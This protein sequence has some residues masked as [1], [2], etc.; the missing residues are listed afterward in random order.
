MTTVLGSGIAA[1]GG[2]VVGIALSPIGRHST[3]TRPVR[4]SWEHV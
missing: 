2:T 3:P 1:L 4:Q